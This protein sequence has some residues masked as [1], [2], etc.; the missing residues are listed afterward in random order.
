PRTAPLS[1]T[2]I[3]AISSASP[4]PAKQIGTTQAGPQNPAVAESA[5][6]VSVGHA[7]AIHLRGDNRKLIQHK[8]NRAAAPDESGNGLP[9]SASEISKAPAAIT[10]DLLSQ[11]LFRALISLSADRRMFVGQIPR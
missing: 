9:N 5:A 10:A 3:R 2:E 8:T 4:T 11:R 7:N 6:A 1:R